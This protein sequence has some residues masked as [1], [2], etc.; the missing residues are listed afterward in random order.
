MDRDLCI[1]GRVVINDNGTLKMKLYKSDGAIATIPN[2][3]IH[4][5][6]GKTRGG[7]FMEVNK[8]RQLRPVFSHESF[9]CQIENEDHPDHYEVLFDDIC[10]KLDCK[11][12]DILD[13]DLCFAD[14]HQPA[15]IGFNKEFIASPRL[16]N[17]FSAFHSVEALFTDNQSKDINVAAFFDHEEIGS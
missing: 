11:R 15:L 4:L 12:E 5:S 10:K 16:D 17:L 14:Y 1:G 6:E 7:N 2:L 3:C 9:D 13:F 8:E